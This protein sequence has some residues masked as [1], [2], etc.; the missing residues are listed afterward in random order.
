LEKPYQMPQSYLF[1]VRLWR[2]EVGGTQSEWRGKVQ[3]VSTGEAH[4]F[5]D[6]SSLVAHLL[7]MLAASTLPPNP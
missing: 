2:E 4:Y 1:T 6:W 7:E 3:Q 5:R